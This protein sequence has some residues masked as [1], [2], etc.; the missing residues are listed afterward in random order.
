[1]VSSAANNH[2]DPC[3][4][5][6]SVISSSSIDLTEVPLQNDRNLVSLQKTLERLQ[7]NNLSPEKQTTYYSYPYFIHLNILCKDKISSQMARTLVAMGAH[8]QVTI[9]HRPL[10][11]DGC[12]NGGKTKYTMIGALVDLNKDQHSQEACD[13]ISLCR[14]SWVIPLVM[15]EC[16]VMMQVNVDSGSV[17]RLV[18]P[19]R[20]LLNADGYKTAIP[21]ESGTKFGSILGTRLDV[22]DLNTSTLL[23]DKPHRI[24]CIPSATPTLVIGGIGQTN[25]VI[26]T[27]KE[28]EEFEIIQM[29]IPATTITCQ[30]SDTTVTTQH[31]RRVISLPDRIIFSTSAGLFEIFGFYGFL[32]DTSGASSPIYST[33]TPVLPGY[34]IQEVVLTTHT[35]TEHVVILAIESRADKEVVL[36]ATIQTGKPLVLKE[37]LDGNQ[38]TLCEAITQ[39]GSS[40]SILTG[41]IYGVHKS[42]QKGTFVLLVLVKDTDEKTT[43]YL[44]SIEDTSDGEVTSFGDWTKLASFPATQIPTGDLGHPIQLAPLEETMSLTDANLNITGLTFIGLVSQHLF[45]WGNYLLYSS[46]GGVSIFLLTQYTSSSQILS[47]SVSH[48]NAFAFI[49]DFQEAAA[50]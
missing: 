47:L 41:G 18:L 26:V 3:I 4:W 36:T 35:Y 5:K 14:P 16:S 43:Y 9:T 17:N 15:D 34:C 2:F 39:P 20:H 8:P 44:V 42:T 50:E 19:T 22:A 11:I 49:N 28:F 25:K 30:N 1:M 46:D 13:G 7:L 40:C 29:T 23:N 45:M 32:K 12:H 37:V 33:L 31:I 38:D 24:I 10:H 21:K 6:V 27:A 48:T